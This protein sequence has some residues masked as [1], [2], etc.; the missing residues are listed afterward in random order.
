MTVSP[1]GAKRMADH[2]AAPERTL[3]LAPVE[4]PF[5]WLL[6]IAHWVSER[7]FGRVLTPLKVIYPRRPAL[8]TVAAHIDWVREHALSIDPPLRL[9]VC[10]RVSMLNECTFC[11]DLI[12]AQ[13]VAHR[14]GPERFAALADAER[15]PHFDERERAAL[16]LVEEITTTRSASTSTFERARRHFS[17]SEIVELLWLNAVENYFNLQAH[18]LGIGSDQL[19]TLAQARR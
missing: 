12:L 2:A 19:Y 11:H 16:A 15:S 9:L 6:R 3:R 17:E 13:A 8:L 14:I 18:P 1:S 5:N 7:R 4:R 10:A